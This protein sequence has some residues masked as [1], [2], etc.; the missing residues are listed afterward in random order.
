MS[1]Y[2]NV[3]RKFNHKLLLT[4]TSIAMVSI[5]SNGAHA[6]ARGCKKG[7]VLY[8]FGF[9]DW[10]SQGTGWKARDADF[11]GNKK[12]LSVFVNLSDLQGVTMNNARALAIQDKS[13]LLRVSCDKLPKQLVLEEDPTNNPD[14]TQAGGASHALLRGPNTGYDADKFNNDFQHG[15]INHSSQ[16]KKSQ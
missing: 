8:H 13:I 15:L 1:K 9:S 14:W 11:S 16:W 6:E 7:D 3:R 2:T 4:I 12:G 5:L 10:K